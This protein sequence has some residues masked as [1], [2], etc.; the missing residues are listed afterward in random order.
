M[1]VLP[2]TEDALGRAAFQPQVVARHLRGREMIFRNQADRLAVV[3]LGE[4]RIDVMG[5]Q[6]RL[7]VRDGYLHIKGGDGGGKRRGGIA[8]HQYDIGLKLV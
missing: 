6:A 1:P 4:G 2:V 7:H 8:V 5:A 3:F